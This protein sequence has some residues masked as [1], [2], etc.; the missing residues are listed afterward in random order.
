MLF[1]STF[2]DEEILNED[3]FKTMIQKISFIY[4]LNED[5]MKDI[6][7]NSINNDKRCDYASLSK[8]ARVTYQKKYKEK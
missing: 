1:D 8:Y 4:K 7:F 6:V 3:S 2:I 5:E